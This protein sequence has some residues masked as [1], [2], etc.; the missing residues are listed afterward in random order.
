MKVIKKQFGLVLL[1]M[2]SL[3]A[4]AET[5]NESGNVKVDISTFTG[6][7]VT[8]TSQ[9]EPAGDGSVTVTITVTPNDGY[10][11]RKSD[12]VVMPTVAAAR[13]TESGDPSIAEPLTLVG[14]DPADLTGSRTY[15]FVVAKGLGAWVMEAD[16]HLIATSGKFGEGES[17]PSWEITGDSESGRTLTLTGTGELPKLDSGTDAP[18]EMLKTKITKVVVGEGVTL[19]GAGLL[20]GCTALTSVEIQ[21]GSSIVGLG[22]NALPANDGLTVDVPGNLYNEYL[23]TEVWDKLSI[24]SSTGVDMAVEFGDN[25]SYDTFASSD[26]LKVPSKLRMFTISSMSEKGLELTEVKEVIPANTPVL[27]YSEKLKG[28]DFKTAKTASDAT[29]GKNLLKLVTAEGGLDVKLGDVW[30]LYHDT[31]Y[32]T[33]AGNIKKGG[34]YLARDATKTRSSYPLGTRD[35][36]TGITTLRTDGSLR[37]SGNTA[38]Y[39]LDGRKYNTMPTRKGI[40]VKDGKKVVI[41]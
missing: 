37:V 16:F 4:N 19:I 22:S 31:F 32:I 23:T 40:Y 2:V 38:W 8:E 35:D 13:K 10:Y 5:Q 9:T 17:S 20:S 34:I 15:S 29:V 18:W 6:G 14:D 11:I 12:I 26:V 21:N 41:K 3:F 36:T 28:N 25:N 1:A 7:T 24:T 30:M 27:A 39:S 33:Q